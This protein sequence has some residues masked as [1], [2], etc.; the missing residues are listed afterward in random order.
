MAAARGQEDRILHGL[1]PQFHGPDAV[2]LQALQNLRCDRIRPCGEADGRDRAA[3]CRPPRRF[4]IAQLLRFRDGRKTSAV[5]GELIGSLLR[6]VFCQTV[7]LLQR[8]FRRGA[9]DLMLVAE[10]AGMRAAEMRN[11]NG[12]NPV[13]G[14]HDRIL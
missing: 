10:D 5:E 4:Q 12:I 2:T 13:S 1:R 14:A 9:G 6:R 11:E 8:F 3:V 7:Q